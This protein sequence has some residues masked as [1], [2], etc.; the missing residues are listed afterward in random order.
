MREVLEEKINIYFGLLNA[1]LHLKNREEADV[2]IAEKL[3][4]GLALIA[5]E[6]KSKLD[7]LV[8]YVEENNKALY[9]LSY[10]GSIKARVYVLRLLLIIEGNRNAT[11]SNRFYQSLY[12]L[13]FS[14]ELME[15][16]ILE[17]YFTLLL[18]A[19]KAD[20]NVKRVSAMMKRMLQQCLVAQSNYT[21]A[22]LL[23][24][25]KAIKFHPEIAASLP[26]SKFS[27]ALNN[28]TGEGEDEEFRDVH[29]SDEEKEVKPSQ[30]SEE[31]PSE[32]YDWRKRDP[33]YAKADRS[34]LWELAGLANH[35]HP[36]ISQWSKEILE[37]GEMVDLTYEGKNPILDLKVMNML[38][39]MTYKEPKKNIGKSSVR[40]ANIDK[41]ISS[42]FKDIQQ[43]SE[44]SK[45]GVTILPHEQF[46]AKYFENRQKQ[47]KTKK[48]KKADNLDELADN[49]VEE[50]MKKLVG[51]ED[52]DEDIDFPEEIEG[53]EEEDIPEEDEP[54]SDLEAEDEPIQPEK[55]K[56][57]KVGK[58]SGTKRTKGHI[59]KAEKKVRPKFHTK[60]LKH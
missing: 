43:S 4:K 15:S 50:E 7:K 14:V 47:E 20:T 22:A 12:D 57:K 5:E 11:P 60:R 2:N 18:K 17:H 9:T 44:S 28:Q 26:T 10:Q 6:H 25:A 38:E 56:H 21:V 34:P 35:Y 51:K 24:F 29:S 37:K 52:E 13:E 32:F 42:Y 49:L 8:H 55:K 30:K 40:T 45:T 36:L 16:S 33:Q 53:G 31:K 23:I 58:L 41:P 39:R 27:V 48:A 46:F 54:F 1:R 19:I 59:Q 3:I